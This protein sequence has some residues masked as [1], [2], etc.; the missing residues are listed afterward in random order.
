M[1]I[2]CLRHVVECGFVI[3]LFVWFDRLLNESLN[4]WCRHIPCAF[5]E[6]KQEKQISNSEV[7]FN[8]SKLSVEKTG[9][10]WH[11][12]NMSCRAKERL[13]ECNSYSYLGIETFRSV[14]CTLKDKDT[15]K[16]CMSSP[17]TTRL[18]HGDQQQWKDKRKQNKTK[19][20]GKG[21]TQQ[22][23]CRY[24]RN[25]QAISQLSKF[26]FLCVFFL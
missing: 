25:R 12:S 7:M 8:Y 11:V 20:D 22:A 6:Y 21:N 15:S 16:L 9:S 2:D 14:S 17:W 3:E 24:H 18:L 1:Y 4:R 26:N 10:C 13:C 23:D 19:E 5:G